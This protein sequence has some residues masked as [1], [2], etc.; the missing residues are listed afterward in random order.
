MGDSDLTLSPHVQLG[1]ITALSGSAATLTVTIPDEAGY[2]RG[3]WFAA[4]EYYSD[5]AGATVVAPTAGTNTF[6][7]KTPLLPNEFQAIAAAAPNMATANTQVDWS[8]PTLVVKAVVAS[9]SG[10]GATHCR[11][12]V[13]GLGV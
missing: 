9:A 3:H 13:V 7:V 4:V 5:S 6:T 8:G 1:T 2:R 10:N 11:L 12:R